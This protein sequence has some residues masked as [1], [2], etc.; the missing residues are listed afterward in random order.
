MYERQSA[1]DGPH[2]FYEDEVELVPMTPLE[3]EQSSVHEQQIYPGRTYVD[4]DGQK[5]P[6]GEDGMVEVPLGWAGSQTSELPDVRIETTIRPDGSGN[7]VTSFGNIQGMGTAVQMQMV[8]AASLDP[9]SQSI[10]H[11]MLNG[12]SSSQDVEGNG[13][14]SAAD[15]PYTVAGEESRTNSSG[16]HRKGLFDRAMDL[17][18]GHSKGKSRQTAAERFR[19]RMVRKLVLGSAATILV[20]NAGAAITYPLLTGVWGDA[21]MYIDPREFPHMGDVFAGP[22]NMLAVVGIGDGE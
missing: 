7:T 18:E 20:F 19:R 13:R 21:Q 1:D 5:F 2:V 4:I 16:E 10:V 22:K 17:A 12:G 14:L 15:T 6:V 8:A 3:P 9:S 11:G